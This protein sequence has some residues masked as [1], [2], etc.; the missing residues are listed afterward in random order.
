[1]VL[2][3]KAKML[4]ELPGHD[5]ALPWVFLLLILAMLLPASA[6][7]QTAQNA[8][9]ADRGSQI[10]VNAAAA[11]AATEKALA[12]IN[13]DYLINGE[14]YIA[15]NL[16]Y[17]STLVPTA[18]DNAYWS[19]YTFLNTY[20]VPQVGATNSIYIPPML[21]SNFFTMVAYVIQTNS[22]YTNL[23]G[24]A[25]QDVGL[26]SNPLFQFAIFYN[27]LLEFTTA[28]TLTITG[29]VHANSNIYVGSGNPLTFNGTVTATGYITNPA[30]G[31]DL[32]YQYTGSV[33]YNGTPA[34]GWQPA[35]LPSICPL[36]S[37]ITCPPT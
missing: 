15:T 29:P 22:P 21:G 2:S 31:G 10:L 13:K 28:G 27:S 37:A 36:A 20:W 14:A 17:Y 4:R 9:D 23:I 25:H 5:H 12:Q 11:D 19:N 30:W 32:Q 18:A 8:R 34:R 24:A 7:A 16:A 35:S 6:F 33:T 1:M 26:M 3:I